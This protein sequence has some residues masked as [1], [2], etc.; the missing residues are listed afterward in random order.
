MDKENAIELP[1]D[2][3]IKS[4]EGLEVD[5]KFRQTIG[6]KRGDIYAN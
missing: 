2:L 1:E 3:F 4:E 6:K 5:V